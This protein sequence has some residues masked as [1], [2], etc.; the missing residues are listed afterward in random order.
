MEETLCKWVIDFQRRLNEGHLGFLTSKYI[1]I[2]EKADARV[3]TTSILNYNY[4]HSLKAFKK[5]SRN[6]LKPLFQVD[7]SKNSTKTIRSFALDFY[8]VIEIS[9]S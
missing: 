5:T 9:S 6:S 8:E 7:F 4:I 2:I 1:E 3:H